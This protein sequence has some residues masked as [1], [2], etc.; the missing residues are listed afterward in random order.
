MGGGGGGGGCI[1]FYMHT[2]V[3]N[4]QANHENFIF[5]PVLITF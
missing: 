2:Q 4:K 5:V 1:T 3:K